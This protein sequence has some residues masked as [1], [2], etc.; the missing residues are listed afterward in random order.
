MY[1]ERTAYVTNRHPADCLHA[2]VDFGPLAKGEE[3]TVRGKFYLVEGNR[4][5]LLAVWKEDFCGG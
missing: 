4:D 2:L 3:R 5:D 1:W